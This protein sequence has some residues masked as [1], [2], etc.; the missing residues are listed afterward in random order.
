MLEP[1]LHVETFLLRLV[2]N[3]ERDQFHE[4]VRMVLHGET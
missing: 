3:G 1:L 2:C 4:V